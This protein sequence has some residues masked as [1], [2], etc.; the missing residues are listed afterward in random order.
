MQTNA[1]TR[2]YTRYTIT[3]D[4]RI[5]FLGR[6][7]CLKKNNSEW[8]PDEALK[9]DEVVIETVDDQLPR[10]TEALSYADID[11]YRR[12]KKLECEVGYF[13]ARNAIARRRK[14]PIADL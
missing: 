14:M 8:D 13:S 7:W 9:W 12:E 5:R 6:Q 4:D 1:S 11:R 10:Q 3:K 2:D